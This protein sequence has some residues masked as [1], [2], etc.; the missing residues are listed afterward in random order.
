MTLPA[1]GSKLHV[2]WRFFCVV[3]DYSER[4]A[5]TSAFDKAF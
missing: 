2:G 3:L 5:F 4:A 1:N